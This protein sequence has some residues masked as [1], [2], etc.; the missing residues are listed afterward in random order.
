M[1]Q[2]L[3]R[4]EKTGKIV[5]DVLGDSLDSQDLNGLPTPLPLSNATVSSS[6]Q[7]FLLLS[8]SQFI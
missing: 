1:S 3:P 2:G 5:F 7:A 4:D 6:S 8:L